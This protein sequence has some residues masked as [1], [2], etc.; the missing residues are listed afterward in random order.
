M[1]RPVHPNSGD[2]TRFANFPVDVSGRGVL[3]ETVGLIR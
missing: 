2:L 1:H 3:D